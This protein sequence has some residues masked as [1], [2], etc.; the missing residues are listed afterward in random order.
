MMAARITGEV[1]ELGFQGLYSQIS[2]EN[3]WMQISK[4][5][6]HKWPQ[7]LFSERSLSKARS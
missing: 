4:N 6:L 3:Y 5:I 2:E 1:A 7:Y